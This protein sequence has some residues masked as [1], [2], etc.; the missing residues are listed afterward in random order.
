MDDVFLSSI[1]AERLKHAPRNTV[2]DVILLHGEVDKD[3]FITEILED[4]EAN[5]SGAFTCGKRQK[6]T[7]QYHCER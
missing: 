7:I 5:G 3:E 4:L 6:K 2:V 1:K